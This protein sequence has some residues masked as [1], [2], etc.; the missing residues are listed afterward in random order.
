MAV[1]LKLKTSSLSFESV[2]SESSAREE[3]SKKE[4]QAPFNALSIKKDIE[5]SAIEKPKKTRIQRQIDPIITDFL[6][7]LSDKL[8]PIIPVKML[9]NAL[10]PIINPVT[11]GLIPF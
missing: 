7:Y 4:P 6:P 9:T 3:G 5:L 10:M 8:P 1:Y 11:D 2:V